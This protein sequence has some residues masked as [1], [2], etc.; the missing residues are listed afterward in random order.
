MSR[1]IWSKW[2]QTKALSIKAQSADWIHLQHSRGGEKGWM[3]ITTGRG[4]PG[5][6]PR[7]PVMEDRALQHGLL[8]LQHW[9][10]V[11]CLGCP[12]ACSTAKTPVVNAHLYSTQVL[13]SLQLS[14]PLHISR[15]ARP[16]CRSSSQSCSGVGW[17][18]RGCLMVMPAQSPLRVMLG[19][20]SAVSS[21]PSPP[22]HLPLSLSKNIKDWRP[23]RG[24]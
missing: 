24:R 20:P 17:A 13:L 21:S 8:P 1:D 22:L 10:S 3:W 16:P 19:S 23:R 6:R 14:L 15:P 11:S 9:E 2:E 12:A 4:G 7:Q 18:V 5:F